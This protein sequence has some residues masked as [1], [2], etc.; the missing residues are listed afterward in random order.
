MKLLSTFKNMLL[1]EVSQRRNS[2][3]ILLSK[4]VD[5]KLIQLK[6]THHQRKERF[7]SETYDDL[8]DMYREYLDTR[9]SKY[10]LEPRLAVPDKMIEIL[11]SKNIEKIY[12]SFKEENPENNRLIFVHKRKNNEDEKKIDYIEVLINK[13]GNFFNIITS[14]FSNDGKF[15]KTKNEEKK[16]KKV[17]L[18]HKFI[19][20]YKIIYL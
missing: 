5:N 1:I 18:E 16:A 17:T 15:L 3:T 20:N 4:L 11:F 14:A 9:K 12:K 13:E 2:G 19:N 10:Q 7:G 8:V 6:S